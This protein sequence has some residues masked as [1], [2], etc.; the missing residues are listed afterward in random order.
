MWWAVMNPS[1]ATLGVAV[2]VTA[3]CSQLAPAAT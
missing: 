1:R 3:T 2:M